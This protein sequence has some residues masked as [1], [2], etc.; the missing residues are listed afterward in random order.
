M[1]KPGDIGSSVIH[2]IYLY[3]SE[4][5][6]PGFQF[7][8]HLEVVGEGLADAEAVASCRVDVECGGDIV[9]VQLFVV[10]DAVDGWHGA[11]VMGEHDEGS[12]CV[13]ADVLLVAVLA[14]ELALGGLS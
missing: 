12:R 13:L 4:A 5:S 7:E 9:G 3:I 11:V 6:E 14:D 8:H 1:G 10:V 2:H